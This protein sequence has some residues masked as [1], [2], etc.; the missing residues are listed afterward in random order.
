MIFEAGRG[1]HRLDYVHRILTELTKRR[2]QGSIVF[3]LTPDFKD[4]LDNELVEAAQKR[5]D[6]E[7]IYTSEVELRRCKSR[8]SLL[9]RLNTY[10]VFERYLRATNADLGF[11]NYLDTILPVLA[12]PLVGRSGAAVAGILFRPTVHYPD[13]DKMPQTGQSLGTRVRDRFSAKAE[14]LI[15][16]Q[17]LRNPRL[18]SVLSLDPLFPDYAR[19]RYRGGEKVKTLP[20]PF[21]TPRSQEPAE[22]SSDRITFVLFGTISHRKGLIETIDALMELS[23]QEA[24]RV[25]LVVA[26]R[27]QG[28]LRTQ[29]ERRVQ[30]LVHHQPTIE[31]DLRVG[32]VPDDELVNLIRSSHVVLAPYRRHV[33]SSGILVWAAHYRRPVISQSYGLMGILVRRY[34]LGLVCN[35][36]DTNALANCIRRAI[37]EGPETL[38]NPSGMAEYAAANDTRSF[39]D[40]LFGALGLM[41]DESAT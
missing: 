1:G 31:V 3:V 18:I 19:R 41:S 37:V 5:N 14:D 24:S 4:H 16:R 32:F 30:A 40:A 10:D 33:G 7:L 6:L 15:Y 17:G 25:R 2:F 22:Q 26:G 39:I 11:V 12:L 29:A 36:A 34:R 27:I 28:D 21:S 20:E 23:P 38:G 35:P 8:S 13:Q 9:R